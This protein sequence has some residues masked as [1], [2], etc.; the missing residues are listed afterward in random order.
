M[1]QGENDL[2]DHLP[3]HLSEPH[4]HANSA[5]PLLR[6]H[7]ERPSDCRASEQRDQYC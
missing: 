1:P 2:P 6:A 7:P 5:H 4:Q 3:D